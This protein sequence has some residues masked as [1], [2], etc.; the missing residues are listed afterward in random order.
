MKAIEERI[1]ENIAKINANIEVLNRQ[2]YQEK[3]KCRKYEILIEDILELSY[4]NIKK[5]KV[6]LKLKKLEDQ[7]KK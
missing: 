3:L 7:I 2:L 1:I 6:L 5:T 4:S